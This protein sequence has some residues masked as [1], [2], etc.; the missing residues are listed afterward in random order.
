MLFLFYYACVCVC[1][2]L[3]LSTLPRFISVPHKQAPE[4]ING[5]GHHK[6]VDYWALGVLIYEMLVGYPP[7]YNSSA[8]NKKLIAMITQK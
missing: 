7:F 6:A 1:V 4:I 2:F 8:D 3:F 5:R